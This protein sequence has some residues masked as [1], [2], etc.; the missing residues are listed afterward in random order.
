MSTRLGKAIND[1][2]NV[3]INESSETFSNKS[4]LRKKRFTTIEPNTFTKD[5][6][7]QPTHSG[8]FSSRYVV[9]DQGIYKK[10]NL[11][12][13]NE[14]TL[15]NFKMLSR[16]RRHQMTINSIRNPELKLKNSLTR[17][18]KDITDN[19]LE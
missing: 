9:G 8:I 3:N 17:L 10:V 2:L 7:S 13:F 18:T 1:Y 19:V 12:D 16:D 14:T 11:I 5:I 4:R 6:L 15:G